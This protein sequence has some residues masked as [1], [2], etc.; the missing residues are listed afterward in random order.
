MLSKRQQK[1]TKTDRLEG[2]AKQV[3]LYISTV[4]S[5]FMQ[6]NAAQKDS[7]SGNGE[8]LDDVES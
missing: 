7:I 1:Q 5:Q 2:L 4:K 3:G 8:K 6:V